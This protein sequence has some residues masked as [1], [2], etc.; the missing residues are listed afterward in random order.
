MNY[1]EARSQIRSGQAILIK[2]RSHGLNALIRWIT[3]SDYTH[4]GLAV[5]IGEGLYLA[6]MNAGGNHLVPLSR[7]ADL[8]LDVFNPPVY[9]PQ[10][11]D[12]GYAYHVLDSLREKIN[13]DFADLLRIALHNLLHLHLPRTDTGGLVCSSYVAWVY[14]RCGWLP[15]VTMPSIPSPAALVA[16]LGVPPLLSINHQE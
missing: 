15:P 12:D 13:Y 2:G 9:L 4:A 7:F 14:R 6:E 1:A 5:W 11:L 10:G 8:P 16:A 3:R